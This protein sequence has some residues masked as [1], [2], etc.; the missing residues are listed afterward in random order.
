M[1]AGFEIENKWFLKNDNCILVDNYPNNNLVYNLPLNIEILSVFKD[2]QTI[3]VW[4]IKT[5]KE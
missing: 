2:E 3:G 4:K 5:L 1:K